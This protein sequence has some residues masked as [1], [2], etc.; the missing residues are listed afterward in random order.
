MGKQPKKKG[1]KVGREEEGGDGDTHTY[2]HTHTHVVLGH[3]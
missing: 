3:C 1:D 2:M